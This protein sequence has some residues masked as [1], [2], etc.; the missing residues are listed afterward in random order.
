MRKTAIVM[1][2]TGYLTSD[3]LDQYQIEVVSLSV[4]IGAESFLET[5]L[6]NEMLFAKLKNIEGFSTTSQPSVGTF[7]EKYESLL[8][9]G[10]EEIVS[11][12]LSQAISGTIAS[13]QMARDLVS[14]PSRIH[15]F[16][17]ASAAL[18]LGLLAMAAGEWAQN[19]KSAEEIMLSLAKI[20][21]LT[22][23]YFIVDTLENLHRGGRIGGASALIGTLL[24]IKPILFFNE[25]GEIDVYDKV[26]S[27][28]RAWQRV[29]DEL[30]RALSS[31]NT[32]RICVLHVGIQEEGER[33]VEELKTAYPGHDIRLFEAGPVIATHVG[34]GAL[35][36]AFHPWSFTE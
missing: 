34:P 35:G 32:Y 16:D 14:Q 29:Q 4:N 30:K 19:G 10:Y 27:Q 1:D 23:L 33:V 25:R 3:I 18:G 15:I 36:L 6:S 9:A 12:H 20:K 22:E 24:Q 26:R 2:S 21:N 5:D 17:S 7:V 8:Q 13:A 31:G 11:I 28:A